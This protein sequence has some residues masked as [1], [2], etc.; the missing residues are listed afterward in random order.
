MSHFVVVY[1]RSTSQLI[2]M[3]EH[4]N[5][6]DALDERWAAEA[7]NRGNGLIE[8]VV[9]AAASKDDLARTHGRYFKTMAQLLTT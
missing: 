8:I 9:L 3:S 2:R 5:R 6:A 1:D 7:E 4:A